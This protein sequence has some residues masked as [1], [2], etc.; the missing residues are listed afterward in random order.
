ME[1]SLRARV[2]RFADRPWREKVQRLRIRWIEAFPWIPLPIRLPFGVWWLA[3]NDHVSRPMI[4]GEF[5]SGEL[6]F[7]QQFL[8]PGMVVL[9]I[10]ANHGLYTLLASKRVGPA[11]KVI[12]FEPSQRE[13]KALR[14]HLT[15]NRCH[16][17]IIRDLALGNESG[18]RELYVVEE[19]AAGCNSLRPPAVD[20]KTTLASV[21]VA[22]LDDVLLGEKI[23]RVD[24][25][26]LDVEGA[27]LDVLKGALGLLRSV[28]R[29]VILVEVY[30]IRTAPWG[31]KAREIVEFLGQN[32][33]RWFELLA[34]GCV[35][36]IAPN[37]EAYDAN[38]VA[39]PEESPSL[40]T[41]NSESAENV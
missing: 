18:E 26:K 20:A 12:A 31:Y 37:L 23:N 6:N 27:E 17:A 16:N 22:R 32:R 30:D 39:I 34:D 9:D 7:V 36:P 21:Q 35:R 1:R 41:R 15:L 28:P 13:R 2:K 8:R 19:R 40:A 38:L 4:E 25:I 14:I 33:Y 24:F 5:E 29:P 11:G 3:R 10:G